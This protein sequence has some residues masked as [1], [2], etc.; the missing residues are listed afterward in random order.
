MEDLDAISALLGDARALIQWGEA[1]DRAGARAWIERNL[2]RYRRGSFGR[3]AI[4]LRSTG[5][6]IGDCG[7]I[8]TEVDGVPE[9]ELGANTASRRVAQKLG[10]TAERLPSGVISRC[11]CTRFSR[12]VDPARCR[13]RTTGRGCGSG[14]TD[15]RSSLSLEMSPLAGCEARSRNGR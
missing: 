3:C 8:R 7:L 12:V 13:R 14:P 5:E 1:L 15:G 9:V 6:L 4:V 2:D 11:S 10:M